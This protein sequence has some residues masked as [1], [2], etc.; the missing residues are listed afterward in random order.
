MPP[1]SRA[2]SR[3][4]LQNFVATCGLSLQDGNDVTLNVNVAPQFQT[5]VLMSATERIRHPVTKTRTRSVGFGK[6]RRTVNE[7]YT[8][9]EISSTTTTNP[10]SASVAT[11]SF[12][13]Q[14]AGLRQTFELPPYGKV[15]RKENEKINAML[16]T[17]PGLAS[18]SED[19]IKIFNYFFISRVLSPWRFGL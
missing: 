13:F 6:N 18:A 8:D 15:D 7:T 19:D 5:A 14:G 12:S 10:E 11:V 2:T 17:T 1:E 9:V 3:I 4:A 16:L